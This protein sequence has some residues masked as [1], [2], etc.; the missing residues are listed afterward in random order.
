MLTSRCT[1]PQGWAQSEEVITSVFKVSGLS[2]P[3]IDPRS[4]VA[5]S[6]GS[7][8]C[9]NGIRRCV[10]KLLWKL[11]YTTIYHASLVKPMCQTHVVLWGQTDER[12]LVILAK[13]PTLTSYR[14]YYRLA[15][16]NR[17]HGCSF[18]F[19]NVGN[20]AYFDTYAASQKKVWKLYTRYIIDAF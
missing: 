5:R 1:S 8:N 20:L 16:W 6:G 7:T 13:T 19:L 17:Y 2:R 3:I 11:Y 4:T 9:V 10:R 14:N 15:G 18:D 12:V